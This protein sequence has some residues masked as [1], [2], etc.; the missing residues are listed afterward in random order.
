M[1]CRD[2][3]TT[4][5]FGAGLSTGRESDEHRFDFDKARFDSHTY[6]LSFAPSKALLFK[7]QKDLLKVRRSLSLMKMLI[8]QPPP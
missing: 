4:K 5:K 2:F 8:E 1:L 6:R 7:H 3:G